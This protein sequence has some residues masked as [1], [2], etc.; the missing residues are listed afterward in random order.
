MVDADLLLTWRLC[1][2][3]YHLFFLFSASRC[4]RER[5]P[6]LSSLLWNSSRL[7]PCWW[8]THACSMDASRGFH[9]KLQFKL[10]FVSRIMASL[11][12]SMNEGS[13]S[14]SS[15]SVRS[16]GTSEGDRFSWAVSVDWPDGEC[17]SRLGGTISSGQS[18]YINFSV[19]GGD[20]FPLSGALTVC[21]AAKGRYHQGFLYNKLNQGAIPSRI[22]HF[23]GLV[24]DFLCIK[25]YDEWQ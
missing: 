25:T 12:E 3:S 22:S 4:N 18:R 24:A 15:D 5:F 9:F 16:W 8:H 10:Q 23:G 17:I 6:C 7:S 21:T 11:H 2:N 1:H 14:R 13:S 19:L 20:R